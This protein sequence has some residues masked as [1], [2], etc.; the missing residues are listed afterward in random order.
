[1][2]ED[3]VSGLAGDIHR[4]HR[5]ANDQKT[6]LGKIVT[7]FSSVAFVMFSLLILST[8][9]LLVAWSQKSSTTST[10]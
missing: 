6:Q 1:M 2:M 8:A 9:L 7:Y 3:V 5:E 4:L 10:A